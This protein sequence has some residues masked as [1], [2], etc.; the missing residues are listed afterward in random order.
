LGGHR[1]G[2]DHLP[3]P[4]MIVFVFLQRYFVEGIAGS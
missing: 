4:I 3:P 1:R 2:R